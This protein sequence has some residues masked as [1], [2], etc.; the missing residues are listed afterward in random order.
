MR[1]ILTKQLCELLNPLLPQRVANIS[2]LKAIAGVMISIGLVTAPALATQDDKSP[3]KRFTAERVFDMEY[4]NDP[5]VSPDAKT[6]TLCGN[7]S[8][9]KR[10]IVSL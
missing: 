1:A 4:A 6:I 10:R 5:Q 3:S 7:S 9:C 2:L 8:A